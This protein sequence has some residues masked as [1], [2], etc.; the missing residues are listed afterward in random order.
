[1]VEGRGN[2]ASL[3][4][5]MR[6]LPILTLALLCACRST[7]GQLN[8]TPMM[9]S[10][11]NTNTALP[12]LQSALGITG[13][14]STGLEK[15]N[16]TAKITSGQHFSWIKDDGGGSLGSVDF[17]GAFALNSIES[18]GLL[19]ADANLE[20]DDTALLNNIRATGSNYLT[21]ALNFATNQNQI[22]P[23]FSLAE[24][25]MSTNAAFTFL[26]PVGVDA[27]KTV[28]QWTLCMVTN[29]TASAVDVTMP[30][31]VHLVGTANVTNL[32][33]FW[34]QCYA[35]KFTNCYATPIF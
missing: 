9:K 21:Q 28:A 30:A 13:A 24:Q 29:T 33:A 34:F 32:T 8:P 22:K 10:I 23:D 2:V 27:T 3:K 11:I 5:F 16:G 14:G 4:L 12:G 15:T 20:V 17:N 7:M 18:L 31:N 6:I 19:K 25:L 35:Q 1:M 26:A